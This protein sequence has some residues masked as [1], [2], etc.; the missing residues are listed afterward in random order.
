MAEQLV[1]TSEYATELANEYPHVLQ[2]GKLWATDASKKYYFGENSRTIY[3]P[4]IQITKGRGDG[5]RDTIM[6]AQRNHKNDYEM[7]TLKRHRF[8]QTLC[9]PKDVME[10][11][12]LV[13]I[14]NVTERFNQQVKFVE[15]DQELISDVYAAYIAAGGVS[16]NTSLTKD[17]ILQVID[18]L[19]AKMDEARVPQKGRIAYVDTYTKVLI[20][21]AKD[22]IRI[23]GKGTAIEKAVSRVGE[24]EIEVVTTDVLK[25]KYDFSGD[26]VVPAEEALNIH[27]FI[28]HPSVILPIASYDFAGL[29]APS[30]S[31]NGKWYYYEES[32]EDF[33]IL[34]E[35]KGAIAFVANNEVYEDTTVLTTA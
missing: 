16:Y 13:T 14:Q 12:H 8:W 35:R 27:L 10:T 28:C 9:H 5:D 25:T 19:M 11:N 24:L 3:L 18:A 30:A 2:F 29:D 23:M 17:N 20:D 22:A 32:F 21:N 34:N 6:A 15:L 33:F 26:F 7:K 1:Y 31:T 4:K